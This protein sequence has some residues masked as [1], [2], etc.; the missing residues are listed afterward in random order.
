MAPSHSSDPFAREAFLR[1]LPNLSQPLP[2][3]LQQKIRYILQLIRDQ[4]PYVAQEIEKL[5]EESPA[6]KAEYEETYTKLLRHYQSKERSKGMAVA[7]PMASSNIEDWANR[8]LNAGGDLVT[9]AQAVVKPLQRSNTAK[10][11]SEFWERGDRV[12][13][14][15]SGGAFLG[16]LLAQVPGAVVGGVLA[17]LFAWFTYSPKTHPKTNFH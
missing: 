5:N 7:M 13:A 6:F 9:A 16:A 10:S 2:E 3:P 12:I 4:K 11:R 8:L 1:T 14:L 17:T 15:G